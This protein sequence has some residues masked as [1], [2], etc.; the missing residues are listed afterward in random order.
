MLPSAVSHKVAV[1]LEEGG[2]AT[3]GTVVLGLLAQETAARA[4]HVSLPRWLVVSVEH[5]AG[6]CP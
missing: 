6:A 4:G 1:P 3:T 5:L 2:T